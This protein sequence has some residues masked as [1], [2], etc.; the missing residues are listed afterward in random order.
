MALLD[1]GMVRNVAFGFA[2]HSLLNWTSVNQEEGQVTMG[3]PVQQ[4]VPKGRV[5]EEE[6]AVFLAT[7]LLPRG[8]LW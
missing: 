4:L 6:G 3:S 5:G 1:I 7:A 2:N 8:C